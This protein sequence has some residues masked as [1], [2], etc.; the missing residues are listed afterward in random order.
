MLE[1]AMEGTFG[2]RPSALLLLLRRAG[3]SC[4][5]SA[6]TG[7]CSV[8]DLG[9]GGRTLK[10]VG[11]G[12]VLVDRTGRVCSGCE[13]CFAAF[14]VGGVVIVAGCNGVEA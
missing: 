6:G 4:K 12:G 1:L 8:D 7:R 5:G 9:S 10:M 3:W 2:L 13:V 14:G 11:V